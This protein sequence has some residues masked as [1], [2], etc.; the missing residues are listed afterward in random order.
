MQGDVLNANPNSAAG[1]LREMQFALRRS[2]R[3][4]DGNA[5]GGT[6][7]SSFTWFGVLG[8]RK[9]PGVTGAVGCEWLDGRPV[10]AT[11]SGIS[12]GVGRGDGRRCELGEGFRDFGGGL[13]ATRFRHHLR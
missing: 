12:S 7:C 1:G 4:E 5:V 11:I 2:H 13:V 6:A 10:L 8:E 3:L 9:V